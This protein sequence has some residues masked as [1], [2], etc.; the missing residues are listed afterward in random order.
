VQCLQGA[1]G[2]GCAK[3]LLESAGKVH[4]GF[5]LPGHNS[6]FAGFEQPA[7]R[8]FALAKSR[9]FLT[10]S[11]HFQI[12]H[13][14]TL[15]AQAATAPTATT[16]AQG[17]TPAGQTPSGLDALLHSPIPMVVLFGV[18]FYFLIIR[19]QS[20]SRKKQLALLNALKAGDKVETASGIRGLVISVKDN[21]VTLK[22][23]DAKLEV[24]KASVTQILESGAST[25]TKPS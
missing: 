5:R 18:V 8:A 4:W 9:G 19:P 3:R 14:I 21:T 24:S 1:V 22:S 2:C 12:M 10:L 25:E 23:I 7:G 6:A 20:Q 15:L 11:G 17:T 16:A 13:V